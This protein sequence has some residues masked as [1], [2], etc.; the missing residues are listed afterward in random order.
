MYQNWHHLLFLHWEIP[1]ADLQALVP[2]GLT[3]D[4]FD[5]K[6]YVALIPF[7]ITGT[8]PVLAP[9]IPMVSNSTR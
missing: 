6:A 8:R 7:T 4:T 1:P 5:G 3:I 9:P 2:A